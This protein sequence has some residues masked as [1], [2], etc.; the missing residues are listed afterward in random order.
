MVERKEFGF[1]R[2][3]REKHSNKKQQ[4]VT[5]FTFYCLEGHVK[6]LKQ[7]VIFHVSSDI[8]SHRALVGIQMLFLLCTLWTLVQGA[9]PSLSLGEKASIVTGYKKTKIISFFGCLL[10]QL[11]K[12]KP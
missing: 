1:Q 3:E 11:I 4:K 10:K 6:M 2:V 9:D 7:S 12:R 8:L 5:Y